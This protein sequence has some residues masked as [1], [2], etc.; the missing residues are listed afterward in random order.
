[1]IIERVSAQSLS[2]E[3]DYS[4]STEPLP[5]GKPGIRCAMDEL[6]RFLQKYEIWIYV[7]LG[8]GS[9]F[10]IQRLLVAWNEWRNTLFGLE[11]ESA[12]RKLSASLTILILMAL[13]IVSEFAIVSFV[14]PGFPQQ[15]L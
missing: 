13:I 1:M 9:L 14:V 2:G 11:R 7:V 10:Y 6:L 15:S 3:T 12:Q 4:Q 8:V 5:G